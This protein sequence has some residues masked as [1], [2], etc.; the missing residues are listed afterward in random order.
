MST[1]I[2]HNLKLR[3]HNMKFKTP[4]S[5]TWVSV[6]KNSNKWSKV[7]EMSFELCE[8]YLTAIFEIGILS[9]ETLRLDNNE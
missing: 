6:M 5:H 2:S 4:D 3:C 1:H 7:W 8:Y 9:P